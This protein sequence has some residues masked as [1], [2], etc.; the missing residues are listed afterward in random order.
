MLRLAK[1]KQGPRERPALQT[2]R[3]G[4]ETLMRALSSKLG[5]ALLTETTVTGISRDSDSSF[6]VRLKGHN[7][8]ESVRATSLIMATPT[9][10]I[11]MLLSSLYYSFALLLHPIKHSTVAVFSV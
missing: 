8:E 5:S 6:E 1:S 11:G 9:D 3:D 2:L 7:G 4:N 10:V